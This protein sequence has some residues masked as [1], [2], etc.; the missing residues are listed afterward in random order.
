MTTRKTAKVRC[1][2]VYDYDGLLRCI[3]TGDR[4]YWIYAGYQTV[5][6][7]FLPD[8]PRKPRRKTGARK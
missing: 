3:G 7:T 2:A 6:G 8:P 1:W 5:R 4:A